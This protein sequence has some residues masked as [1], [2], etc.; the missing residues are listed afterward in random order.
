MGLA[1]AIFIMFSLCWAVKG[2][3]IW[4]A[5]AWEEKN[6]FVEDGG[7]CPDCFEGKMDEQEDGTFICDECGWVYYPE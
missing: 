7:L 1:F 4:A 2:F 5:N 3:F 6:M